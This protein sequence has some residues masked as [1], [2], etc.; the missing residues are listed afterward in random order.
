MMKKKILSMILSA[1]FVCSLAACGKTE[2]PAASAPAAQDAA[3]TAAAGDAAAPEEE[4]ITATLT[5]W[6]PSEDQA[7]DYGEWL[8]T[9]CEEF[10]KEHPNWTLTFE[11]GT[12]PEDKAKE[13]IA[14]DAAD[15]AD[16][17]MFANDQLPGLISANAIAKLGGKTADMVKTTNSQPVVDSVTVDGNIYAVPFSTN[18]WFMYYDKSVFSDEDIKNMDTMLEKGKV[19]FPLTSSWYLGAFYIANG[20]TVFGADGTDEAAGV[21]FSGDKAVAV[22]DYLVDLVK[23]PNF[24][25]DQDG[26][27]ISGMREGTVN[28]M[29]SGS[30][31]ASAVKEILGDNLGVAKLPSITINGEAKQLKSFSGTKAIG[32]NPACEYPQVAVALAA[33]LGGEKGQKAHYDLR[34]VIPCNTAV[35]ADSAVSG[36]VVV[37]AQD[38]TFNETSILQPFVAKMANFW[39]P[40]RAFGKSLINGE[41]THDNAA[42]MTENYNKSL[43][44]SAVE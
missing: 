31:K 27:G 24:V 5:V 8:Q 11:Y 37:K 33:Y 40:T 38:E 26:S 29:F 9:M 43:N 1:A 23:N 17:Y 20:C 14:Q 7:A 16:V 42:A 35:L 44:T 30:W 21:D 25:I 10:K 22:T 3:Q 2:T 13:T 32:V 6:S 19:S 28:A 36:D 15:A 41:I 12:C 39:D 18:T 34:G 4:V